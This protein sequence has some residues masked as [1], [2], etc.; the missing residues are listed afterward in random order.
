MRHANPMD[1][2]RLRKEHAGAVPRFRMRDQPAS[3][4][5]PG[6]CMVHV[7][8]HA[9][10]VEFGMGVHQNRPPSIIRM[11]IGKNTMMKVHGNMQIISGNNILTGAFSAMAS[12][13][14]KRSLRR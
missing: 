3:P 7:D 8:A 13:C 12:A 11:A 4:L 2:I 14:M 6:T 9:I 10:R 1:G 5:P